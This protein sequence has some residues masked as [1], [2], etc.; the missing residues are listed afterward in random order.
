MCYQTLRHFGAGFTMVWDL[1]QTG[2]S[3]VGPLINA[4]DKSP[5]TICLALQNIGKILKGQNVQDTVISTIMMEVSAEIENV[6]QEFL[7]V[8]N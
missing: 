3:T 6:K 2:G 4:N 7:E 5:P 1:H 8:S